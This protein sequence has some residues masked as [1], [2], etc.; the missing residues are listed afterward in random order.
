MSRTVFIETFTSL[1]F[2]RV[3][4]RESSREYL[5]VRVFR[6]TK[7]VTFRSYFWRTGQA[8]RVTKNTQR[9]CN[10]TRQLS[11][12]SACRCQNLCFIRCLSRIL[13][14][15]FS[16]LPL[17]SR[18]LCRAP[19]ARKSWRAT[20]HLRFLHRFSS[21]KGVRGLMRDAW[22]RGYK[23][24]IYHVDCYPACARAR[25]SSR[26]TGSTGHVR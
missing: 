17:S 14:D 23:S 7:N 3:R 21:K 13:C 18:T 19:L 10:D 25:T 11:T 22:N 9:G 26:G 8:R 16:L 12:V 4:L 15:F 5:F 20:V 2:T 24:A 6:P 1:D